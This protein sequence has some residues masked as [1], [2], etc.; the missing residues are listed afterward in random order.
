MLAGLLLLYVG[1]DFANP[2]MPGAVSFDAAESVDGI[3]ADRLRGPDATVTVAAAPLPLR[4]PP[5]VRT[6]LTSAARPV[7]PTLFTLVLAG[8]PPH[9]A[10]ATD[11]PPPTESD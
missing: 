11:T 3:R 9:A 7:A 10:P 8:P 5:P 1:A 6:R 2:L 4:P